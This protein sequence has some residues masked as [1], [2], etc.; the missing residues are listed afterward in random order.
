MFVHND[1]KY[2]DYIEDIL[3]ELDRL[4]SNEIFINY[5]SELEFTVY[6]IKVIDKY[7]CLIL[8]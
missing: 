3:K 1:N 8:N 4:H 7:L 2:S 6:K 5:L